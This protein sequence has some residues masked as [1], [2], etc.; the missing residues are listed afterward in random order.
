VLFVLPAVAPLVLVIPAMMIAVIRPLV[1]LAAGGRKHDESQQE[2]AS[3]G[4]VDVSQ[5]KSSILFGERS[6]AGIEI[7]GCAS[8]RDLP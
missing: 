2:E 7:R 8:A 5:A 1:R 6:T 4:A 3:R